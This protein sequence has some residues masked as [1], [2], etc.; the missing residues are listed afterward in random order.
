MCN[1]LLRSA[2]PSGG[3]EPGGF[4]PS[5]PPR[6]RSLVFPTNN[7]G[8]LRRRL[9]RCGTLKGKLRFQG[10]LRRRVG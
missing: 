4:H 10:H 7:I 9:K 2:L 8:M 1:I 3:M 5:R 6:E